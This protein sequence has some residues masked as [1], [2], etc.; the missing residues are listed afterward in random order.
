MT[1]KIQASA[2]A[3]MLLTS[4][5]ASPQSEGGNA[6]KAKGKEPA[7]IALDE[8]RWEAEQRKRNA[9]R[10]SYLAE[11][12]A[13][14]SYRSD[15]RDSLVRAGKNYVDR[16][17]IQRDTFRG[18]DIDFKCVHDPDTIAR[19]QAQGWDLVK[20]FPA[21]AVFLKALERPIQR[22]R[23][24][25]Q[26]NLITYDYEVLEV[27]FQARLEPI[28]PGPFSPVIL[29]TLSSAKRSTSNA[30]IGRRLDGMFDHDPTIYVKS[31]T[32]PEMVSALHRHTLEAIQ[33][34]HPFEPEKCPYSTIAMVQKPEF[35][36]R[37]SSLATDLN[38]SLSAAR[39]ASNSIQG[40]Q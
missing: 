39:K 29:S 36:L 21:Y 30:E 25:A 13:S 23:Q 16:Q 31:I 18:E 27:F 4:C 14:P 33:F 22:P 10:K 20:C 40:G 35:I 7:A 37:H 17:N 32:D 38:A 24:C 11:L 6:L 28:D 19:L 12:E 15:T 9:A 3:V 26:Q 2:L 8:G 5:G 34:A 1:G